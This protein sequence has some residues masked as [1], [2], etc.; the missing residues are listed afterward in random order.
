MPWYKISLTREQ[1]QRQENTRLHDRFQMAFMNSSF[2]EGVALFGK[3]SEGVDSYT[4]YLS[5]ESEKYCTEIIKDYSAVPCNKPNACDV[6]TMIGHGDAD[7][8]LE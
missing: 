3:S 1:V 2:L 4:L 7:K 8:L 5:P 6:I